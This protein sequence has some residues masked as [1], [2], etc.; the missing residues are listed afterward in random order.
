[1]IIEEKL[2][3]EEFSYHSFTD[4]ETMLHTIPIQDYKRLEDGN[5]KYSEGESIINGRIKFTVLKVEKNRITKIAAERIN[6]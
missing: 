3:G 4:G 2:I 5:E 1:M 6:N